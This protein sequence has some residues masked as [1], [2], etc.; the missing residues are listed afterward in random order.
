MHL[1]HIYQ[2]TYA[3]IHIN[4]QC[5]TAVERLSKP[6]SAVFL[7]LLFFSPSAAQRLRGYASLM[8]LLFPDFQDREEREKEREREVY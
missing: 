5:S 3:R 1:L 4:T 2:Y 6:D 7:F 8:P